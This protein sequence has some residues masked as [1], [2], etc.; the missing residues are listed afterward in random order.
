H[1][2]AAFSAVL[3]DDLTLVYTVTTTDEDAIL[4]NYQAIT[5]AYNDKNIDAF[6]SYYSTNYLNSGITHDMLEAYFSSFFSDPNWSEMPPY[7]V[8]I[9][10]DGT[11]TTAVFEWTDSIPVWNDSKTRTDHWIKESDDIWRK[12][13][14]QEK[15]SAQVQ[16]GHTAD[17]YWV[18]LFVHDGSETI[19]SV[20]VTGPG[21][22]G[23]LN[24]I[25]DV[26]G[27]RWLSWTFEEGSFQNF[28]PEFGA[29]EPT[30]PITYIFTISDSEGASII[31]ATVNQFVNVFTSDLYPANGQTVTDTL[32][33]SW[34][35]AGVEY[36]YDV[37]LFDSTG[38]Y[39]WSI[40]DIAS[41]SIAYN[42]PAL[43]PGSYTYYLQV[44]D[45]YKNFSLVTAS[46]TFALSE[47]QKTDIVNF[48]SVDATGANVDAENY[49]SG[50]GIT[51]TG[52]TTGTSVI[53][54]NDANMY[55]GDAMD[56]SS[57]PN[58]LT[59]AGSNDPVSFT[60]NFSNLLDSFSFTR[61]ILVAATPSGIIHPEW[62]AHA[63][64]ET[65]AEIDAKSESQINSFSDVPAQT[66]TLNGPGI[67]SVR[68]DSN[69]HHVAAFSAVLIDDLTLVYT[70]T[71]GTIS[72]QL[73][74]SIT[75]HVT[76]I[77]GAEIT[78]IETGQTT[79]SDADGNYTLADVLPGTYSLKIEKEY[80]ETTQLS[81]IDV[82]VGE[83]TSV[84]QTDI[85]IS[86]CQQTGTLGD[87]N[88]DGKVGLE[89]AVHALQVTSGIK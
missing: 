2:V 45:R 37:M 40:N 72:G 31:N 83:T 67:K 33:F 69:N 86:A 12:Y 21:I 19:T 48:D 85:T 28:G 26:Y 9:T 81:N 3:I 6:M 7:D 34:S 79:T 77:A 39:V 17:N 70:V 53:I 66:F 63:L 47:L 10:V 57:A 71:T 32:T 64:D 1:H 44:R 55:N 50:F 87:I 11:T 8:T 82:I 20:S 38:N 89:E 14:N 30:T 49:L 68:F 41:T 59:Q 5:N 80:F 15:Y 58:F 75:G 78:I 18:N 43:T 36:N 65:G 61:P 84:P 46:F 42:G 88:G 23:D 62:S 56:P 76:S 35:D 51:L 4:A 29:T 24:L 52:V 54:V 13:G 60:L 73:L 27:K 22:D 25:H 16:S 74:T